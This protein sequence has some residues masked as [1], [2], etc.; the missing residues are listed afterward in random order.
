[1]VIFVMPRVAFKNL[2]SHLQEK[3]R[4]WRTG[5]DGAVVFPEARS[6]APIVAGATSAV[7]LIVLFSLSYSL[8]WSTA[9]IVIFTI[10]TAIAGYFI[11]QAL[12]VLV[13]FKRRESRNCL[14]VTPGHVFEFR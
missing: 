1:Q 9:Q 11:V 14:V 5:A 7:W 3:V 2:P 10:V 13:H 6:Y 4:D 12:I 8:R